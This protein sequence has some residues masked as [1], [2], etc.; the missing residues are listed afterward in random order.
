[1]KSRN[2]EEKLSLSLHRSADT[3]EKHPT[4]ILLLVQ[5][6]L[7]RKKIRKRISFPQ[8]L[9]MQI[10]F[11]G[12]KIWTVQ[13]IILLLANGAITYLYE[14][15]YLKNPYYAVKLLL[16]LSVLVFMTALPFIYRSV[17]YQM[18]EIEGAALFSSLKLLTAKLIVIAVGDITVLSGIFFTAIMKTSLQ[19]DKAILYLCFPFLLVSSGGLFMLGRFT[20]KQFFSGCYGLCSF[21]IVACASLPGQYG[22]LLRPSFSFGLLILCILLLIFCIWQFRYLVYHSFY[23]ERQLA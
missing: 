9:F 21:V 11:M 1:M 19:A 17:R 10:R 5:N 7:Y 14:E 16:C 15:N 3:N 12:W 8:F 2:F 6:E 13:G 22:V 18:Q 20:P 23:T 4:D